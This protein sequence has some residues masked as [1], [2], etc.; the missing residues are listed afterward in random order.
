[1]SFQLPNVLFLSNISFMLRRIFI[2]L[3]VLKRS[4]YPTVGKLHTMHW[5]VRKESR[6][7]KIKDPLDVVMVVV[8]ELEVGVA[9]VEAV[10]V[11]VVAP[12]PRVV[13]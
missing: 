4:S 10:A 9:E 7:K 3:L 11:G 12:L 8:E 2:K 1:M 13:V 5:P 6:T